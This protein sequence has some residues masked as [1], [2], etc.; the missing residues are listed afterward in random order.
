MNAMS[1]SSAVVYTVSADPWWHPLLF[2][3]ALACVVIAVLVG[4]RRIRMLMLRPSKSDMSNS[5]GQSNTGRQ[6]NAGRRDDKR[7]VDLFSISMAS[8]ILIIVVMF[9]LG[10]QVVRERRDVELLRSGQSNVLVGIARVEQCSVA[11]ARLCVVLQG[12]ELLMDSFFQRVRR[13]DVERAVRSGV[14]RH[15]CFRIAEH[16][17]RILKIE[18]ASTCNHMR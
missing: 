12:H 16:S 7:R 18:V 14:E 9:F 1:Q 17:G 13:R 3:A 6:S 5:V 15:Q 8:A 4:H 2:V 11:A 10:T